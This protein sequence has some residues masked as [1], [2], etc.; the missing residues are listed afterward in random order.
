MRPRPAGASGVVEAPAPAPALAVS[1]GRSELSSGDAREN[2]L[3]GAGESPH[4]V[5]TGRLRLSEELAV[6]AAAG[7]E[8]HA[9]C[10]EGPEAIRVARLSQHQRRAG[11]GAAA[12]DLDDQRLAGEAEARRYL[13]RER[14]NGH[15]HARRADSEKQASVGR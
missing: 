1:G 6:E 15:A 3:D 8:R 14:R 9:A 5:H 10:A 13:G 7:E 2:A 12:V 4:D 11:G